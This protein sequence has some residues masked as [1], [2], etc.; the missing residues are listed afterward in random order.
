[1]ANYFQS[2]LEHYEACWYHLEPR[3]RHPSTNGR[4]RFSDKALLKFKSEMMSLLKAAAT[5]SISINDEAIRSEIKEHVIHFMT[6]HLSLDEWVC[7][8]LDDEGH[9]KTTLDFFSRAKETC[10]DFT[11]EDMNQALRNMWV[12]MALQMYLGQNIALTNAAFGY[13]MLY[14]LTDNYM[15]NT[16]IKK[17]DKRSFNQRFAKKISTGHGE[18]FNSDEAMIFHMINLI[19]SDYSRESYPDVYESLLAILDAQNKSLNQHDLSHPFAIN[20]LR[21]TFYKGGTSV[22]ADAY[23]VKGTLT[24]EE[25]LFAFGYG[26]ALQLADDFEDI[27]T[28]ILSSHSTMPVVQSEIGPLDSLFDHYNQFFDL[29]L[30]E[31]MAVTNKKQK[32]MKAL[33]TTSKTYLMLNNVYN[34]EQRFGRSYFKSHQKN[35]TFS[36]RAF[37]K[38]NK[39]I[40]HLIGMQSF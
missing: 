10:P 29:I 1:M 33:L 12:I 38:H 18:A 27:G 16:H 4:Q 5:G 2:L 13:S 36:R 26:I 28:D 6:N 17:D 11:F 31:K 7:R 40:A 35:A 22:L 15:D 20:L 21:Q 32:A 37:L 3:H 30:T 24:E 8:T 23:L 9:Y 34:N 25:T 39:K 19:A 14:P